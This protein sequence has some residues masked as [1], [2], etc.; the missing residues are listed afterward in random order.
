MAPQCIG[1]WAL[2]GAKGPRESQIRP[3]LL[4]MAS[5][6]GD[7]PFLLESRFSSFPFGD[8]PPPPQP[9]QQTKEHWVWPMAGPIQLTIRNLKT[10]L[11]FCLRRCPPQPCER[12]HRRKKLN[13]RKFSLHSTKKARLPTECPKNHGSG[14]FLFSLT[15][16]LCPDWVV[17]ARDT[18]KLRLCH[19]SQRDTGQS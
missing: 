17:R 16:N 1:Q 13:L 7:G 6:W 19:L 9:P 18:Q 12:D 14:D 3:K 5:S 2:G 11:P 10:W 15:I 8:Y 4:S